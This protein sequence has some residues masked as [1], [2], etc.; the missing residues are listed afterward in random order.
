MGCSGIYVFD[1]V[2]FCTVKMSDLETIFD[3][4]KFLA[5][6]IWSDCMSHSEFVGQFENCGPL[7]QSDHRP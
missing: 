4:I 3:K 2:H 7:A 6:Y 5:M 1:K